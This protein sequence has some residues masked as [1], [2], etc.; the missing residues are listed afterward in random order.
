[1]PFLPPNQQRQST[2]GNY[3]QNKQK[4]IFP[5]NNKNGKTLA[6]ICTVYR[7][8]KCDNKL[9]IFQFVQHLLLL[10]ACSNLVSTWQVDYCHIHS[11]RFVTA[12]DRRFQ[13]TAKVHHTWHNIIHVVVRSIHKVIRSMQIPV[14]NN[15]S[16]RQKKIKIQLYD[17]HNVY[18]SITISHQ[19]ANNKTANNKTY[20]Y[21]K[22]YTNQ[23]VLMHTSHNE[24][25][26]TWHFSTML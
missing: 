16:K 22:S 4:N 21:P 7:G 5:L 8:T 17:N 3:W 26:N 13:R 11:V 6:N 25:L 20:W 1:M 23:S 10:Q 9:A 2:E 15:S 14:T 18:K 12:R 19:P 24:L